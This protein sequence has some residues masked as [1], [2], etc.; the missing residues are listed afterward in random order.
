VALIILEP[1][2]IVDSN[3]KPMTSIIKLSR[4]ILTIFQDKENVCECKLEAHKIFIYSK[5]PY[6]VDNVR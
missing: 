4:N 2:F 5:T 3:M 1:M 6:I